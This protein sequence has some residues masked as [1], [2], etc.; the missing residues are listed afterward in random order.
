[1]LMVFIVITIFGSIVGYA[2]ETH[3]FSIISCMKRG[4]K[5]TRVAFL[6]F[7]NIPLL[8]KDNIQ[9]RGSHL[10][11]TKVLRECL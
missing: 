10:L 6:P 11:Q 2:A 3:Y 8:E 4:Q 9:F 7:K 1:M 5:N